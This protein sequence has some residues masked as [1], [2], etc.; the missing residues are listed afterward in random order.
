[1][2]GRGSP[3]TRF[4]DRRRVELVRRELIHVVFRCHIGKGLG[5]GR[6]GRATII[7]T[8]PVFVGGA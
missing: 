7:R 4:F 6:P 5:A 8:P 1:M 3:L 2:I